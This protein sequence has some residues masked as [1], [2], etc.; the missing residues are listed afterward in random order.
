MLFLGNSLY[1]SNTVYFKRFFFSTPGTAA[2]D[3]MVSRTGPKLSISKRKCEFGAICDTI[4]LT[5]AAIVVEKMKTLIVNRFLC[6]RRFVLT[7]RN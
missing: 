7:F 2:P 3:L 5:I 6:W 1:L 4:N